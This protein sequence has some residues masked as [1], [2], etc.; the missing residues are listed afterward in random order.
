VR[1]RGTLGGSLAHSDP[2][3]DYPAVMLAL[4]ADILIQGSGGC[5]HGEGERVLSGILHR[6]FSRRGELIVG[7]QFAPVKRPRMPSCT[8]ARRTS[9]S[10][11]SPRRSM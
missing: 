11:A 3:A 6:R 1:N 10:S 5:A 9:P 8:S 2:A 7:V 4:D